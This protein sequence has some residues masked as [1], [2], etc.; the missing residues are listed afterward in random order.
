MNSAASLPPR[1]RDRTQAGQYLAQRLQ[2]Y[3][4]QPDVLV[5]ALPRGGVPVAAEVAK[6]LQAP[7][8][9]CLVRKLGV[10]SQPELAMGAIASNHVMVLNQRVIDSLDITPDTVKQVAA[11][12]Q[13]ELE[14][15]DRLYR[16][17]PDQRHAVEHQTV[18]LIDDGIATGSTLKAAIAILRQQHP[19]RIVVATPVAPPDIAQM[20]AAL[21]DEVICLLTPASLR[22]IGLWYDDFRQTS[23]AEVCQ[24]LQS[25]LK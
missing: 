1:F 21:V 9:L 13:Q 17:D 25:R 20:F 14:R 8:D 22:A 23:D 7:L 10:P 18:I 24:L 12:E 2:H 16:S 6:A 3:A 19:K 4:D 5:L 11:K 15:R